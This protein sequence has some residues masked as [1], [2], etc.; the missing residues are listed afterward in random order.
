MGL[1]SNFLD[2]RCVSYVANFA[3]A[4]SNDTMWKCH[5]I[6]LVVTSRGNQLFYLTLTSSY[7][8][9]KQAFLALS[10]FT[11]SSDFMISLCSLK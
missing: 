11:L 5:S 9:N 6:L 8:L 4:C 3:T 7:G 10:M 2:Y 1:K